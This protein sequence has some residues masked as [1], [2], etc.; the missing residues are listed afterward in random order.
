MKRDK[1]T[2]SAGAGKRNARPTPRLTTEQMSRFDGFLREDPSAR[3]TRE[4]LLKAGYSL[5]DVA[6]CFFDFVRS[7]DTPILDAKRKRGK[8]VKRLLEDGI[9][10]AVKA[11]NAYRY[12]G[13]TFR[14]PELTR[15]DL[16]FQAAAD[17]LARM[18]AGW[19]E[20]FNTKRFGVAGSWGLLVQLQEYNRA[21]S[22]IDLT[23]VDLAKLIEAVHE[24]LLDKYQDVD[25]ETLRKNLQNFRKRNPGFVRLV[26]EHAALR[27]APDHSAQGESATPPK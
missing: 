15:R 12:L 23:S 2:G 19:K 24:A 10:G 6:D 13:R 21:E 4:K 9:K 27:F 20:A 26:R 17:D 16:W 22:G 3:P 25:P 7:R 1:A 5:Q 14:H 18:L 8:L 11:A